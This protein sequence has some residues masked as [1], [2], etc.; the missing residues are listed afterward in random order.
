MTEEVLIPK[1]KRLE[2]KQRKI[3]IPL[4]N[5]I[6]ILFCILLIIGS[7]FININLKHY[8]LSP[9]IFTGKPLIIEDFIYSFSIIPQI[10]VILFICS[11]LGKKMANTSIILYI[12][13]GL[14]SIPVFALGGGIRYITEFSFGYILSY[15]PAVII[16]GN[17]LNKKYSFKNMF[18]AAL[19][20]VLTIHTGGI[21]YMIIIALLKHEGAHFIF[22]W[23]DAQ[24]GLKIIYDII[25]SFILVLIGKYIHSVLK[26]ILE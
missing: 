10:P 24:S 23:I 11:S 26:F 12:L 2:K 15:I 21:L 9:E 25:L 5:I 7:T 8:I 14:C 19:C 1:M 6:L 18:L 22:S 13:A 20:G 3:K 16:A 4:L 17:I